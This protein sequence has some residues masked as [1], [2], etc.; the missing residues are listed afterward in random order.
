MSVLDKGAVQHLDSNSAGRDKGAVEASVVAAAAAT[1]VG[2]TRSLTPSPVRPSYKSG[3]AR[4]AAES[5]YPGLWKGMAGAWVP[6]LGNTG[7][8]LHDV[9]GRNHGTLTNMDPGTDWV[10]SEH[11]PV[12]DFDGSNDA[13]VCGSESYTLTPPYS[14]FAFAKQPSHGVDVIVSIGSSLLADVSDSD[15]RWQVNDSS[16]QSVKTT[17]ARAVNEWHG[18]GV[19]CTSIAA[20]GTKLYVDGADVGD[21]GTTGNAAAGSINIGR[22]ASPVRRTWL[23]QI[24]P[25]YLWSRALSHHEQ[26][27]LHRDPL[28]PFRQRRFTPTIS[29]AAAPPAGWQPYWAPRMTQRIIGSGVR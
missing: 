18:Y 11:G 28:A 4:S 10:L 15:F 25:V 14:L 7:D 29:G 12:L 6:A 19:S 17:V 9:T 27:Q 1:S 16:G 23:G 3:F 13:V 22:Q 2:W 8:T 21:D 26:I 24:G 5:A 20:G